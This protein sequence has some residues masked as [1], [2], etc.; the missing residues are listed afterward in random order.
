[1]WCVPQLTPEFIERME[2]LLDLYARPHDPQQPLLCF[3][4]KSKQLLEDTRPV[5]HTGE[6]KIRKR[7]YE[8]KRHGARNMFVAVEPQGGYRDVVV[9]KPRKQPDFAKA[10]KR[11]IQLPRYQNAKKLHL[12]LDNLNIHGAKSLHQTFANDEAQTL[13]SKIQ[14]HHRPKHAS[15]LNMA[16][17]EIGILS[18]QCIGRRMPAEAQLSSQIRAWQKERNHKKATISWKFTVR[19]ARRKFAYSGPKLC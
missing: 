8:Y 17:V 18:R 12:V 11:I 7:D 4:E 19:D 1:M 5:K 9:T 3:D 14:F 10:I 16:E 15:W 2:H 6:G 13:L